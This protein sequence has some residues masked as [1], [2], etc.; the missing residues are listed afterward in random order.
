MLDGEGEVRLEVVELAAA[1]VTHAFEFVGEYVFFLEQRRDRVGELNLAAGAG[2][3]VLKVMEDARRED[4]A[5]DD[6]QRRRRVFGLRFLHDAADAVRRARL[7]FGAHD[8]VAP[9][10]LAPDV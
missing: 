9:R 1:V 6:A 10:L 2:G 5:S 3:L 8:A 7:R 4:I